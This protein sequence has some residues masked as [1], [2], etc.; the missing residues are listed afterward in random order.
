MLLPFPV[1]VRG[2]DQSRL[3]LNA[4]SRFFLSP[5]SPPPVSVGLCKHW[6]CFSAARKYHCR[7][8]WC[9]KNEVSHSVVF[10]RAEWFIQLVYS[11]QNI[12]TWHQFVG[13]L[14][15]L[16]VFCFSFMFLF[17][18]FYVVV[19][20]FWTEYRHLTSDCLCFILF[21]CVFLCFYGFFSSSVQNRDCWCYQLDQP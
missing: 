3:F 11:G 12:G 21:V 18:F 14:F 7:L 4:V 9:Q 19:F 10:V 17:L 20:L 16:F 2:P 6:P 5:Q 15:C 1:S 13:V 8:F